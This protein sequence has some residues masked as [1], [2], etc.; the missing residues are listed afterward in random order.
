MAEQG[1]GHGRRCE[2]CGG[3]LKRNGR[4][5]S[6][7]IRWR[8]TSCGSSSSR[9]RP[10]VTRRAQAETFVAWL[11]GPASQREV[12]GGSGR[13]FRDR[14]AWC[15]RIEPAIAVTGEVF[16][17][18]QLDGIYLAGG[19][20]ALIPITRGTVVGLQWCDT[21]KKAAWMALLERLP[22][23]RAVVVDGGSGLASALAA[24]WPD[25]AV[26]RCLV[27]VQRNVRGYLTRHP[28]TDAGRTL[29][30]LSLQLT[31]ITTRDQ[32]TIWLTALNA[33]HQ[34]NS[35]LIKQRTYATQ[36]GAIRPQ[37]ARAGQRWWYTHDRIR[38]AYRLMARLARQ[39]ALFTYLEPRFE[40]LDISS[41]TNQIEGGINSV[42]RD[43]LKRHRGMTPEH[44][45]RAVEWWCYLHSENPTQPA[46]LAR[47]EHWNPQPSPPVINDKPIDPAGYDTTATAEEGLWARKGWA[48][49]P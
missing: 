34:V 4:T 2:V 31:K 32:A 35:D 29:R 17:E 37:W 23:P 45:K 47:P 49:R 33:W 9:S 44:Q 46:D 41:T 27:H 38:R 1:G 20:C 25:T 6:G 24:T 12:G 21:E 7:K 5:S 22:A 40:G 42:L 16:D 30:A 3:W 14:H 8:C 10:D 39:D 19:W 26:Q 11:T 48:G 13:T 36:P 18:V 28:R 15:W 43:L